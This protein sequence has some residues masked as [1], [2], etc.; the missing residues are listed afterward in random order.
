MRVDYVSPDASAQEAADLIEQH[1]G[2]GIGIDA[3]MIERV[4]DAYNLAIQAAAAHRPE[5]LDTR[6]ALFHRDTGSALRR[7]GPR[8]L[9]TGCARPY[10][11]FDID[12]AHLAM[13][14]PDAVAQ[15]ARILNTRL[16]N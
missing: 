14:D 15:I 8:W 13:T 10:S 5:V 2:A 4:T 11:A 7:R 1:L 6:H 3:A 16:E 12:T 9:D